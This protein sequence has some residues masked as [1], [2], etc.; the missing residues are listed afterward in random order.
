MLDYTFQKYITNY[1]PQKYI[2][3]CEIKNY[4]MSWKT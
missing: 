3:D 2:I 1:M 4:K